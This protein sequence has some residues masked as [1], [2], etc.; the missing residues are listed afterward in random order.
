MF[1]HFYFS[2]TVRASLRRSLLLVSHVSI[3]RSYSLNSNRFAELVI[4]GTQ[5]ALTT[6]IGEHLVGELARRFS[7][8]RRQCRRRR[9]RARRGRERRGR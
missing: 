3:S 9:R 2:Y 4:L 1:T 7:C 8:E 5:G 6:A